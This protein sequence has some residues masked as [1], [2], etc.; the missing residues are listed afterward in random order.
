MRE[1]DRPEVL[2]LHGNATGRPGHPRHLAHHGQRIRHVEQH[3]DRQC[4]V[5]SVVR[6]RQ[7]RAVGVTHGDAGSTTMA[8]RRG[9]GGAARVD[10]GEAAAASDDRHEVAEDD[11]GP[12]PHFEHG[13][14]PAHRDRAQEAQPHAALRA[15]LSACLECRDDRSGIGGA[16]DLPKDVGMGHASRR[17]HTSLQK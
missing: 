9:N 10:P 1:R 16:I 17:A 12:A 7:L 11:A 15:V 3:G 14:A 5:E 13:V 6:E 8:T 2:V 4:D